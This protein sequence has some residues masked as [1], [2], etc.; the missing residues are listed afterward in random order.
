[1]PALKCLSL[2]PPWALGNFSYQ[3]VDREHKLALQDIFNSYT[4]GD[5][6]P[7][8]QL[9]RL[10]KANFLRSPSC[11]FTPLQTLPPRR[12]TELCVSVLPQFHVTSLIGDSIDSK[13]NTWTL[14][15]ECLGWSIA[16]RLLTE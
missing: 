8:N 4:R 5:Y 13:H 11:P 7:T 14:D 12:A 16:D 10:Q 9:Q 3:S 2:P 6:E 15:A 1:M